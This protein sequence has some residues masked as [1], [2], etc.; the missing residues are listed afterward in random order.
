MGYVKR[1]NP[2]FFDLSPIYPQGQGFPLFVPLKGIIL[3]GGIIPLPEENLLKF[4]L[5]GLQGKAL[6]KEIGDPRH[7]L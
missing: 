3:Q 1:L 6:L 2:F 4:G 5:W 7:V